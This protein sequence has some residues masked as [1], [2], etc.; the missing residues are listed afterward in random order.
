MSA[1]K[2]KIIFKKVRIYYFTIFYDN[3]TAYPGT[4]ISYTNGNISEF[5][6]IRDNCNG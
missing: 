1:L 2:L 5:V 3:Q 4:S 6:K